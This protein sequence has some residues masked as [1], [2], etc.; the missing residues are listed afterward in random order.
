MSR[1]K[2]PNLKGAD[3]GDYL[4]E[5]L[6]SAEA[7]KKFGV[8]LI[9]T[10]EH[11]TFELSGKIKYVARGFELPIAFLRDGNYPNPGPHFFR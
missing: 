3:D 10:R 11:L 9:N 7:I 6:L 2:C 4:N 1:Q 8:S 5:K